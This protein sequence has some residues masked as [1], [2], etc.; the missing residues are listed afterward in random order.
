MN[1]PVFPRIPEARRRAQ[2]RA[3][4][5]LRTIAEKPAAVPPPAAAPPSFRD[6]THP[7]PRVHGMA[8]G[9]LEPGTPDGGGAP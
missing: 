9:A 7:T 5:R 3:S 8:D 2:E 4:A 1:R 6:E